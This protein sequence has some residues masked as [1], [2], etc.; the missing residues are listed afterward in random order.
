MEGIIMNTE[1]E[2]D[3]RYVVYAFILFSLFILGS[4]LIDFK[5]IDIIYFIMLMACLIKHEL[6]KR[7]RK[8]CT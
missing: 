4:V 2:K 1:N 5:P 8:D 3:V 7:K 6:I